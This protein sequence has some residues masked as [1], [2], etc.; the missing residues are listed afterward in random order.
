MMRWLAVLLVILGL[1]ASPALAAPDWTTVATKTASG[2]Y[3]IGNPKAKVRLVEYLSYTCPHCGAFSV[4][5][6]ATLKGKFVK[7]GSTSIEVRNAVRDRVDLAA[8]Q[9]ARCAAPAGFSGATDAIFA[10]QQ[11]WLPRAFEYNQINAARLAGYPIGAQLKKIATGAGLDAL[12]RGRGMS[13]AAID[14]CF[15]DEAGIAAIATLSDASWKAIQ[16][17]P[18]FVLNGKPYVFKSWPDLEAALRAA[19]AH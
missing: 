17:T 16:S 1:A 15:A 11:E 12:M 3:V 4:E 13:D 7:S 10:Q 14:A 5:S 6:S 9:L 2:A 8:A 19:G 18:S